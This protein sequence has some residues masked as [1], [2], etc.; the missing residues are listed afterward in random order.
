MIRPQEVEE[1]PRLW[2]CWL[3]KGTETESALEMP[4][5]FLFQSLLQFVFFSFLKV[6]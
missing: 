6:V 1:G 4:Y 2:V 5:S 3:L